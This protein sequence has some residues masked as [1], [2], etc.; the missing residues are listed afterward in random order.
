MPGDGGQPG[1]A[2]ADDPRPLVSGP[3]CFYWDGCPGGSLARSECM[4][5]WECLEWPE[6]V[7]V[8]LPDSGAR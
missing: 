6:F 4:L 8:I 5:A 7:S 2:V 3:E 1:W